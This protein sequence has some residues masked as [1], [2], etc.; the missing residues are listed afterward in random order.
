MLNR[1]LTYH[2]ASIAE[3]GI[4]N[5]TRIFESRFGWDVYEI[6]V[7]RLI[8][9]FP[10]ITFTRLARLTKF[11]RSAA[12]RMLTRLIKAGLVQ[13]TN[14]AEDARQFTLT[15]TAKGQG[16]CDKA[17]PLSLELETLMLEPLSEAQ[18]EAF[19][20]MLSSVLGWVQGGYAEKVIERFPEAKPQKTRGTK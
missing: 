19:R 14:S 6:R 8:R 16:L 11:E 5:A 1:S 15:I 13:R 20:M 10:G 12:S 2:L 7:L 4:G 17:D 3:D 9:D 18:K